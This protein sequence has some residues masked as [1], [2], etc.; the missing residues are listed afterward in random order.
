M[1]KVIN[2]FLLAVLL[3]IPTIVNASTVNRVQIQGV[4]ET[5]IGKEFYLG[6]YIGVSDLKKG[7][8]DSLGIAGVVY[9]LD[10]DDSIFN[11]TEVPKIDS[12]ETEV[13]KSEG[14]Y[15]VVSYID[16]TNGSKNK[17]VDEVLFCV[18]YLQTMKFYVK[19][20]TVDKTEIKIND[21]NV[22]L[23]PVGSNYEDDDMQIINGYTDSYTISIKKNQETI[24]TQAPDSVVSDSSSKDVTSDIKTNVDNIKQETPQNNNEVIQKKDSNNFLSSIEITDYK[25]DFNKDKLEYSIDILEDVNEL[26]IKA[27]PESKTAKVDIKGTNDLKNNDYKII[28]NVTAEDN[29]IRTY[30]IKVNLKKEEKVEIIQENEDKNG[31]S[32]FKLGECTKKIIIISSIV[33]VILILI[34]SIILYK[35]DKEIDQQLDKML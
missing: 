34:I 23:Y 13:Y 15:F 30:S 12:F 4:D 21:I 19:D 9:E 5:T 8:N 31:N 32:K 25:I 27:I 3:V 26:D 24:N 18:D 7:T 33:L 2:L 10:F 6:F 29:N 35:K 20:T 1:K 22:I 28:I 17:C 11:I 16:E 14:K